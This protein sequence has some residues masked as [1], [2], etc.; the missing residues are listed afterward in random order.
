MAESTGI[1][2][3]GENFRRRSRYPHLNGIY[4]RHIQLFG[5]EIYFR[6]L[7][8]IYIKY[9]LVNISN[10][11]YAKCILLMQVFAKIHFIYFDIYVTYTFVHVGRYI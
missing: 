6:G 7:G 11:I 5:M 3:I 4:M 8:I 1:G 2:G 10:K 9:I